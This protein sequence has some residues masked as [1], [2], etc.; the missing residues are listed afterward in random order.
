VPKCPPNYASLT[1]PHFIYFLNLRDFYPFTEKRLKNKQEGETRSRNSKNI[2]LSVIAIVVVDV[3]AA[4]DVV[5]GSKI[6][7]HKLKQIGLPISID[8]QHLLQLYEITNKQ[9]NSNNNNN[10]IYKN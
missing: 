7:L 2:I 4:V 3:V 1:S 10:N 5:D 8:S 9:I 6:K